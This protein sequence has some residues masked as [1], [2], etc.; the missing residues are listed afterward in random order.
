MHQ[1]DAIARAI[2][3]ISRPAEPAAVTRPRQSGRHKRDRLRAKVISI[4][5]RLASPTRRRTTRTTRSPPEP[6]AQPGCRGPPSDSTAHP[7]VAHRPAR[8]RAPPTRPIPGRQWPAT[9]QAERRSSR[10]D[11]K[12]AAGAA[13]FHGGVGFDDLLEAVGPYDQDDRTPRRHEVQEGLQHLG[14]RSEASPHTRPAG[15]RPGDTRS[16]RTPR[17]G[18]HPDEAHHPMHARGG[19][20]VRE[21]RSADQLHGDIDPVGHDRPEPAT[22]DAGYALGRRR[23][24]ARG[25]GRSP[26]MKNVMR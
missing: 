15:P 25:A 21:R 8:P 11:D 19:E 20:R 22:T 4:K 5:T 13:V 16:G 7:S 23:L 10:R 14:D 17:V 26:S 24:P 12:F 1:V 9:G 3:P 6:D 18:Q 2:V